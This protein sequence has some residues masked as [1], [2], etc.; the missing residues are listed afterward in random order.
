MNWSHFIHILLIYICLGLAPVQAATWLIGIQAPNGAAATQTQWQ[1]WLDWLSAQFPDDDFTLVALNTEDFK[2]ALQ[3]HKLDFVI[4]QPVQLLMLPQQMPTHWLASVEHSTA[5]EISGDEVGSAVWVRQDSPLKQLSDLKKKRVAAVSEHAFGGHL[6]AMYVLQQHGVHENDLEVVFQEY[7]V[8]NALFALQ[9]GQ[10]DAAIAP[11]CLMEQLQRTGR[12]DAQ[13]FRLL[14][15]TIHSAHCQGNVEFASNWLLAAMPDTPTELSKQVASVVLSAH[16]PPELPQ[17]QSPQSTAAIEQVLLQMGH[18]PYQ[19]NLWQTMG[20]YAEKYR[21]WWLAAAVVLALMLLNHALAVYLARRRQAQLH[22]MY[23]NL[24]QTEQMMYH[25]DRVHT[26]GEMMS[27]IGHELNQPLTAIQYYADGLRLKLQ[28]SA[29][30][31]MD[32]QA[33]LNRIV[34]QIDTSR[35]IIHNIRTWGKTLPAQPSERVPLLQ[36]LTEVQ[37]FVAWQH[38]QLPLLLQCDPDIHIDTEPLKLKQILVNCILNS[39]Q[40]GATEVRLEALTGRLNI[41]DNGKGFAQEQLDFPFVPFR[42]GR[43]DGLGIGLVVC[44]RLARSMDMRMTLS[45]HSDG[46]AMVVLSWEQA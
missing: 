30:N 15:P 23:H 20:F 34:E 27:G 39:I 46:G 32:I 36:V 22:Q 19:Q 8:A 10:V 40:A 13:Q 37:Q 5:Y 12:M 21:Y 24:A 9:Q 38:S 6:A 44:E 4:A 45:N 29:P 26:L 3:S 31:A 41:I 17:W 43:S 28:H 2:N 1:P 16:I 7:P 14:A 11:L 33:V 18:H 42:T 25:A 35:H